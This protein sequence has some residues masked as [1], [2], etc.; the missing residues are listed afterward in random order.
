MGQISSTQFY[1]AVCTTRDWFCWF[2]DAL[3]VGNFRDYRYF[4]L[5]NYKIAMGWLIATQILGLLVVELLSTVLTTYWDKGF[6]MGPMMPDLLLVWWFQILAVIAVII[7]PRLTAN[8]QWQWG[9]QLLVVFGWC[10]MVLARMQQNGMPLSSELGALCF[11]YFWWQLSEQ[12]Y[13]RHAKHWRHV[14][15][16]DTLI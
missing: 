4:Y 14:L 12:Q 6:K 11:G 13:R 15:E 9:I 2:I 1:T 7:V 10:L 5:V 8:W 3:L 16:I